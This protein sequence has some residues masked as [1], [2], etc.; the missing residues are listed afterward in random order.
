MATMLTSAVFLSC[1]DDGSTDVGLIGLNQSEAAGAVRADTLYIDQIVQQRSFMDSVNTSGADRWYVGKIDSYEFRSLMKFFFTADVESVT[2]QSANLKLVTTESYGGTGSLTINLH[3]IKKAWTAEDL[4]WNRFQENADFGD[5]VASTT[6]TLPLAAGTTV[7]IPIPKDTVQH[8]IWAIND[9]NRAKLNNGLMMSFSSG[10][11][12]VQQF[13]SSNVFTTANL[14]DTTKAAFLDVFYSKF[15]PVNQVLTVDHAF[16]I[17]TDLRGNS[18][19]SGYIYR[20]NSPQSANTLT[21]GGGV[22][23]RSLLK[24]NTS[25]IATNGTIS[26]AELVMTLDQSGNYLFNQGDTLSLQALRVNEDVPDWKPGMVEL[27]GTDLSRLFN[28]TKFSRRVTDDISDDTL[29]INI[30][31]LVHEW[32]INP[33]GNFGMQLFSANEPLNIYSHLFRVRFLSDSLDREK[34]PKIILTYTLP[35]N[36]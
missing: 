27:N 31:N 9:S 2:V 10:A 24:F 22:P 19:L 36:R 13:Y 25:K 21:V 11:N 3:P 29:R 6:I 15:N 30:T 14:P 16:S 28:D 35:P 33:S 20:D 12:V 18:G 7:I 32:A 17:P 8:W 5:P 1:E 23:Y 26:N 34:S 4:R